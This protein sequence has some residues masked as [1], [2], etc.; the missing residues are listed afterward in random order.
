MEREGLT[1]VE[2]SAET[3]LNVIIQRVPPKYVELNRQAFD[4]GRAV[5][6]STNY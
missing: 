4:A 3:W 6:N 5:V 1:G 2:L